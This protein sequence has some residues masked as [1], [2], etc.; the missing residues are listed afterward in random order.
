M[1]GGHITRPEL[2]MAQ[3][4]PSHPLTEFYL[5]LQRALDKAGVFELPA[6]YAAMQAPARRVYADEASQ[7]LRLACEPKQGYTQ[8]LGEG[9]LRL[10]YSALCVAPS[11]APAALVLTEECTR[12][13]CAVQLLPPFLWDEALP[14]VPDST[15]ALSL[16]LTAQ[17]ID[18]IDTAAASLGRRMA[19]SAQN[20]RWLR[21][22]K[23]D[24]F[25]AQRVA[26]L[27]RVYR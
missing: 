13:T 14:P 20:K 27:Q 9:R 2:G 6:L 15:S 19:G 7:Y 12:A 18:A 4:D 8:L 23:A 5:L 3:A 11:G 21:H 24:A 17:D 22:P 1:G 10:L 26:L 25:L 16:Q